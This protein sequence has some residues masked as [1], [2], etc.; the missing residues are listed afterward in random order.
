MTKEEI[1]QNAAAYIA[2]KSGKPWEFFTLLSETWKTNDDLPIEQS[3]L[4]GWLCRPAPNII[5]WTLETRPLGAVMF[6]SKQTGSEYSITAWYDDRVSLG[7]CGYK[8]SE[9]LELFT[10]QDGSPCGRLIQP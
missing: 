7:G 1:E 2:A 4:N 8:Y 3:L 9:L 6:K 5:P 10:L